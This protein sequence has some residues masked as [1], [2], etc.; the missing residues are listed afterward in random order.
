MLVYKH[1]GLELYPKF[2]RFPKIADVL[3]DALKIGSTEKPE[4]QAA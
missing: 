3:P 1:L 2:R 4:K